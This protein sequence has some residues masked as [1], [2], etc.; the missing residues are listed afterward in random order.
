KGLSF[1][2]GGRHE[3]IPVYDL[4]GG[5]DG[6]RRPGYILSAEPGINYSWDNF[7]L[8]VNI[9]VALERNR[10]QSFL[11]KKNSTPGNRRH[12]DAAF[13]DYLVN[14][15]FAWRLSQKSRQVFQLH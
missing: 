8:N 10:T 4:R 15:G 12:G 5:S 7:S 2:L 14:L 1:F 13:A 3:C 6:C 9:P 11:D